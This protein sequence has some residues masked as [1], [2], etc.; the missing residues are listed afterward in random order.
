MTV[1]I[2][3][4]AMLTISISGFNDIEYFNKYIDTAYILHSNFNQVLSGSY[5]Q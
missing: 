2:C 1:I 3:M 5:Y 4:I